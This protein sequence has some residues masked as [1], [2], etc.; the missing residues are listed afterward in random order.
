MVKVPATNPIATIL[1]AKPTHALGI[2]N[3]MASRGITAVAE[4]HV[5]SAMVVASVSKMMERH[6]PL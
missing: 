5:L 2:A 1:D 4:N 3:S 6:L